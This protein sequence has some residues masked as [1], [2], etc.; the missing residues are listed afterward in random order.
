MLAL[1]AYCPL[2]FLYCQTFLYRFVASETC[3]VGRG[4]R[5][6]TGLHGFVSQMSNQNLN[7][8]R[9]LGTER[10]TSIFNVYFS[11]SNMSLCN[12]SAASL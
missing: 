11:M 7:P 1:Y 5:L 10:F 9:V 3:I 12:L 8:G 4:L 6:Q 2:L